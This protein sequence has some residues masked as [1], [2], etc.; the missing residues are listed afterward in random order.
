MSLSEDRLAHKWSTDRR[1]ARIY[2][3]TIQRQ[4]VFCLESRIV[5]GADVRAFYADLAALQDLPAGS[6]VL[7]VPCGGG[8]AF[9]GL[10]PDTP[11][12]YVAADVSPIMLQRAQ[13][14]AARCGLTNIEYV[15]T[16][17]E[18]MPFETATFD[19]CLSYNALHCFSDPAAAVAEMARV[20]RQGGKLRGT[21]VVTG[22]SALSAAAIAFF[23]R[24]EQFGQVE[25]ADD[26]ER[27]LTDGG[28]DELRLDRRGA[29]LFF[30]G[31]RAADK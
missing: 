23:R 7:D 17:V 9:R 31:R 15:R 10:R 11:I 12:R 16:R 28:F 25:S 8:V 4:S 14:K 20:L 19:L 30:E 26:I 6:S 27:R 21:V 13:A 22:G 24:K 1:S 29:Y 5:W 2:D 18:Q 3:F